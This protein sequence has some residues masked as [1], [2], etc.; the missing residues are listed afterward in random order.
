ME[1]VEEDMDTVMVMVG[2]I[3]VADMEEENLEESMGNMDK[4]QKY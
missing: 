4:R 1:E 2:G 3:V